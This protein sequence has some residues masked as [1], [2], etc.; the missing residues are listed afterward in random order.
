MPDEDVKQ[1]MIDHDLDQEEAEEVRDIMDEY[2]LDEDE[3][4][5][6]KDEL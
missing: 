4:M 3:A 6:L 2:D 1:L 5:E